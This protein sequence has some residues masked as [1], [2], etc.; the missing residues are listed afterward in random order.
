MT[1]LEL[2]HADG[3][4]VEI[5]KP[6][7]RPFLGQAT[8]RIWKDAASLASPPAERID[9]Q[10]CYQQVEV[11]GLPTD[12]SAM[13]DSSVA[14]ETSMLTKAYAALNLLEAYPDMHPDFTGFTQP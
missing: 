1:G 8:V 4:R 9:A 12:Y 5:V 10:A 3:R 7:F 2:E 13:G 11:G 14:I 6:D